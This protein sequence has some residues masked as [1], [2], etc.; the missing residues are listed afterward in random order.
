HGSAH[1]GHIPRTQLP[2]VVVGEW[3]LQA[4]SAVVQPLDRHYSSRTPV[5]CAWHSMF[6]ATGSDAMCV[7]AVSTWTASTVWVPPSASGPRP[8]SLHASNNSCSS[9]A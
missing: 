7:G 3:R 6:T 4:D 2:D 5:R 1:Q 8:S 9:S